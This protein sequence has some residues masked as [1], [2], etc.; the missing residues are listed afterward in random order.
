MFNANGTGIIRLPQAYQTS[1]PH[2]HI[3]GLQV[4]SGGIIRLPII[5]R[6]SR[7]TAFYFTSFMT[8]HK[9]VRCL[10]TRDVQRPDKTFVGTIIIQI[11]IGNIM[12]PVIFHIAY[13]MLRQ[14]GTPARAS[15]RVRNK[16]NTLCSTASTFIPHNSDPPDSLH[17]IY[18]I[19]MW[20]T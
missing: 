17:Q 20:M 14:L 1:Q 15:H 16:L 4:V 10:K 6:L 8:V 13:L 7:D 3:L 12:K 9:L 5:G 19:C 11:F 2:E 18:I